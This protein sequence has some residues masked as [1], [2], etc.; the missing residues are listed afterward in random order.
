[1]SE[2]IYPPPRVGDRVRIARYKGG[3]PG[4][5]SGREVMRV[6]EVTTNSVEARGFASDEP[7][8]WFR[9]SPPVAWMG[10]ADTWIAGVNVVEVIRRRPEV[11]Y[12]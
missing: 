8:W 11:G 5:A 6:R 4:W 12:L 3:L 7:H 9:P 1:M 10:N 2:T